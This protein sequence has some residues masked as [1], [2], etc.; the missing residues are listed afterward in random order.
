MTERYSRS[1]KPLTSKVE[2]TAM[3]SLLSRLGSSPSHPLTR[4][5]VAAVHQLSGPPRKRV[6]PFQG[7]TRIQVA[8]ES[9]WSRCVRELEHSRL[10][11]GVARPSGRARAPVH[12]SR[13]TVTVRH[14]SP[15]STRDGPSS[16]NSPAGTT[17][18]FSALGA[19]SRRRLLASAA[20]S[21]AGERLGGNGRRARFGSQGLL[22]LREAVDLELAVG[23]VQV[24]LDGARRSP[25]WRGTA[26]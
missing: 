10:E 18:S 12:A 15:P 22:E 3:A 16:R 2:T 21:R 20:P 6:E 8:D 9:R 1:V 11:L 5:E 17:R 14:A 24:R 4:S 26:Q 7:S 13:Y 23:V 25:F 19:R